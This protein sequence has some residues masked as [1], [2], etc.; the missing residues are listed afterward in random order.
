MSDGADYDLAPSHPPAGHGA[1]AHDG[2]AQ[3]ADDD[4]GGAARAT[5]IPAPPPGFVVPQVIVEPPEVDQETLDAQ[6]AE[7]HK[8]AAILGYLIFFLPLVFAPNSKFARHHANQAMLVFITGW[9]LGFVGSVFDVVQAIVHFLTGQT[10]QGPWIY[11]VFVW[12]VWLLWVVGTFAM[13]VVGM[14]NAANGVKAKL[15]LIGSIT[16]I[17]PE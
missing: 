8:A 3:H 4:G 1:G 6:D 17:K 14:L 2:A 7:Q 10:L 9:G 5:A 15:P 12:L 11:S 16:L 13:I